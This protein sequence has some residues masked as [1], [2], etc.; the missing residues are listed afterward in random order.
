MKK[1]FN[2]LLIF[3]LLVGMLGLVSSIDF[4]LGD[5]QCEDLMASKEEV[6]GQEIP[7]QIP[8][9]NEVFEIFFQETLFGS[10]TLEEKI[11]TDLSC[12]ENNESTYEIWIKDSSV[13]EDI[14]NSE[15]PLEELNKKLSNEEIDIKGKTFGKKIKLFFTK[16][17]LKIASW[18]I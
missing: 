14:A 7:S 5:I 17:I 15:N 4:D 16:I 1:R 12:S 9:S 10:I 11:I 6:V 3:F 18:F 8:Y 2:I 13:I